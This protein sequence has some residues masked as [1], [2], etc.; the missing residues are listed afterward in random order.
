MYQHSSLHRRTCDMRTRKLYI[1]LTMVL[2][3]WQL[4]SCSS[5]QAASNPPER[6]SP[7]TITKA[8]AES[9]TLFKQRE[10]LDKLR[11]AIKSVGSVRD[12]ENRN[13]Q[14]EWTFAKYNYFLGK[15]S[16]NAEESEE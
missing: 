2:T 6:V 11:A 12:P 5:E 4:L 7:E 9:E 8:L 1:L 13:Y 15:F 3:S 14:V 10:D 16:T